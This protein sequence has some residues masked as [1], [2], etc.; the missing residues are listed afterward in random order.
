MLPSKSSLARPPA[1]PPNQ[2]THPSH[3]RSPILPLPCTDGTAANNTDFSRRHTATQSEAKALYGHGGV[4][5]NEGDA[6]PKRLFQRRSSSQ[7][8]RDSSSS[9][10]SSSSPSSVPSSAVPEAAAGKSNRTTGAR[11]KKRASRR[12]GSNSALPPP[13]APPAPASTTSSTGTGTDSGTRGRAEARAGNNGLGAA[14]P[15]PPTAVKPPRA[16]TPSPPQ[17]APAGR[18][19]DRIRTLRERC[20]L[21]LGADAFERAYG[22]LKVT[23]V[24]QGALQWVFVLCLPYRSA[25]SKAEQSPDGLSPNVSG[26]STSAITT[27]PAVRAVR[28]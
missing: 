10:S 24:S 12:S 28:R 21:G 8:S 20:C 27:A 23:R 22:Y 13:H 19:A 14:T 2:Q 11:E 25:P 6:Q 4:S 26:V 5:N 16:R 9:S 17:S 15:P 7:A 18:L 1:R 3:Y